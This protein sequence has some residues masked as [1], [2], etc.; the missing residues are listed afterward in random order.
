VALA[1]SC[2]IGL[3]YALMATLSL[4]VTGLG[5]TEF[6]RA[7]GRGL[8]FAFLATL[9]ALAGAMTARSAGLPALLVVLVG[10]LAVA[11]VVVA[12]VALSPRRVLGADL[13]WFLGQ[14]ARRRR[15]LAAGVDG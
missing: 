1:V 14:V 3:N 10:T 4:R 13:M 7:H 12:A 5:W 15:R 11:V 6:G 8:L 2:A 9:G